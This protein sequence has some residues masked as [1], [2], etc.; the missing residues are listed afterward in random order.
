MEA[1]STVKILSGNAKGKIG[2][3]S[4]YI[5]NDKEVNIILINGEKTKEKQKNI[6]M[7]DYNKLSDEERKLIDLHSYE[8]SFNKMG[9][10]VKEKAAI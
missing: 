1:Y 8:L 4:D 7:I 5:E 3:I 6:E 9:D 2:I 10:L